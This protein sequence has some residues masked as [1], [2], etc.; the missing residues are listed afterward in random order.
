VRLLAIMMDIE[1]GMIGLEKNSK[2]FSN[3]NEDNE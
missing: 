3:V 1:S 2:G